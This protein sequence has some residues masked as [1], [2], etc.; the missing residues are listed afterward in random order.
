MTIRNPSE[1]KYKTIQKR[2]VNDTT[3][4]GWIGE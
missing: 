3:T 2:V 1:K 4:L